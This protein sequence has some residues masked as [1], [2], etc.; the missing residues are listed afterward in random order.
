M[1][2]SVLP[3][4]LL[5]S[6][7]REV[8]AR[9]NQ[10]EIIKFMDE[11]PNRAYFSRL[12]RDGEFQDGMEVG[13]AKAR[14]SEHLLV[15]SNDTIR[16]W[17]MVE[18]YP[19]EE[20]VKRFPSAKKGSSPNF[21]V[22]GGAWHSSGIGR[23]TRLVHLPFI[24]TDTRVFENVVVGSLD[25]VY[26]DSSH[27]YEATTKELPAYW[28]L[29]RPG[30]VLAGHDYCDHGEAKAMMSPDHRKDCHGC[31]PVPRC[32][33][34]TDYGIWAGKKRQGIGKSQQGVVRAVQEWVVKQ[35][36]HLTLHYTKEDF[37]PSTLK[38]DGMSF[39]QVITHTR[40]PS[41]FVIKPIT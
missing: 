8:T 34:Y 6:M 20:F 38:A 39:E 5:M 26:I 18:P 30:G 12:F 36:A 4:A 28:R 35:D 9:W 41:W 37:S 21:A 15:D 19:H 3:M 11:H 29:L 17:F 16:S 40:N 23:K 32:G 2:T 25:F 22:A 24:S 27:M 14:F 31:F 13:V 10:D 1:T 7:Q 33:K